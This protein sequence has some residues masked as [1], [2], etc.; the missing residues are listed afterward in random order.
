MSTQL[1]ITGFVVFLV[2]ISAG[3]VL[4]CVSVTCCPIFTRI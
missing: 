2:S 1:A 4:K 3:F